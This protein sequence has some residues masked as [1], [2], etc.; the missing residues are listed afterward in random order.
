MRYKEKK[1]GYLRKMPK[2]GAF[3]RKKMDYDG[4]KRQEEEEKRERI[5]GE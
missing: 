5:F 4:V 1:Q 2:Q 3:R